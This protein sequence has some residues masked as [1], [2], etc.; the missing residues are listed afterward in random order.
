MSYKVLLGISLISLLSLS[1]SASGQKSVI[2]KEYLKITPYLSTLEDVTKIYGEGHHV[3]K[4]R[5]DYLSIDYTI[6]KHLEVSIDY[7]RDCNQTD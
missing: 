2:R 6:H 1:L 7:F 5:E 4:R 3:I